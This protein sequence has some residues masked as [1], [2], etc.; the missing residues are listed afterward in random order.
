MSVSAISKQIS[1]PKRKG[2]RKE[3]ELANASDCKIALHK[4][5]VIV[6]VVVAY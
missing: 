5:F 2:E 4:G 1:S 6:A 3:T